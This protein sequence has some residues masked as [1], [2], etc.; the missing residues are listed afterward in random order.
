VYSLKSEYRVPSTRYSE[1]QSSPPEPG[2]RAHITENNE[3][4][5]PNGRHSRTQEKLMSWPTR[6][7]QARQVHQKTKNQKKKNKNK[8]YKK[9][10]KK[11]L[12]CVE[13]RTWNWHWS[14]TLRKWNGNTFTR[15]PVSFSAFCWEE[16]LSF[17]APSI[18]L[19]LNLNFLVIYTEFNQKKERKNRRL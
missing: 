12:E 3:V 7:P 5:E 16:D 13:T 4:Y 9:L 17:S 8:I 1:P 10:K 19:N 15:S 14:R 2:N 6:F 18:N 11:H